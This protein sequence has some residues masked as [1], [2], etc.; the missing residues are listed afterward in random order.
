MSEQ[1]PVQPQDDVEAQ[2]VDAAQQ[3]IGDGNSEYLAHHPN[4]IVDPEE[5]RFVAQVTKI[6]E[7]ALAEA[8]QAAARYTRVAAGNGDRDEVRYARL[9][10]DAENSL[11]T[12]V[13][14]KAHPITTTLTEYAA[15]QAGIHNESA[16]A[17][18]K[19]SDQKIDDARDEYAAQGSK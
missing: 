16:D 2:A 6:D 8:K 15:K 18:R 3:I 4:A 19:I 11:P 14:G 10:M 5:A 17:L 9:N 12:E 1:T 7:T 13:V